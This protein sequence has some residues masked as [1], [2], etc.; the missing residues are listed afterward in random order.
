MTD[1]TILARLTT[2]ESTAK[3]IAAVVSE[4]LDPQDTACA[5]FEGTDGCWQV[6][7]HFRNVPDEAGLR[8]LV[9]LVGGEAAGQALRLETLVDRD[10]VRES[11]AGLPPV[12][13]GRFV[14]HGAHDRARVAPN[15]IGI[16]IEAALAF[17]TGHHGT[18]RGCLLGLDA[19]AKPAAR[20]RKVLDIGT[21]TGVLAIAAARAL[22]ARVLAS[23][24]DPRAVAAARENARR[25]RAAARIDLIC[26]AGA[27]ARAVTSR[28]PFDL[29]FANIL[30]G[31]LKA[32]ARPIARLAAPGARVVLSGLLAAQAG[33]AL[34]AYRAQG[35]VLVRR[36]P[37]DE[38]MTLVLRK[39]Q[40]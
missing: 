40:E 1:H 20:P 26:A 24:I 19:L 11:L 34:A 23:D 6:S 8:E 2:D 38:W 29:I 14:V 39:S 12:A 16:E 36:I 32:L 18:T 4:T 30:L 37:L 35:L 27:T 31:P 21:G 7:L 5:A 13:A 9:A 10:W 3:R 28:A 33:N 22:N 25:N 17:G 15:R